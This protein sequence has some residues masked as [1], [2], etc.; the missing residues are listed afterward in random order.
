[1][2][3]QVLLL[4][5]FVLLLPFSVMAVPQCDDIFTDPP[6]GNHF[7]NGLYPPSDI[8]PSLGNLTCQKHGQNRTCTPA[9]YNYSPGDYNFAAGTFSQGN[10]INTNG[11]STRL[12]FDS[13][14]LNQARL[15]EFGNTE[16]LIIYVR[17]SLSI[18]GQNFINGIVY[19]AGSVSLSGNASIDGALASGGSLN[20]SGNGD[21]DFDPDAI[22]DADFGGMCDNDPQEPLLPPVPLQCPAEQ[23]GIGGVTY[24]SYDA[25][26]WQSGQLVSPEDH[27]EFNDLIDT[28]K[29]T[30]EQLGESI[31]SNISGYGPDINP[32]S[33]QGDYY[34]G[35]F[36]GY[37][38]VPES[39]TYTFGI[40]GDDAI[41]LLIDDQ[42]VVGFYGLHSRCGFACETGTIGLEAGTHKVE[43]RF[44]EADGYEA[45]DLYWQLPSSS[46]LVRVPNTVYLTCPFPEFEFGRVTLNDSGSATINFDNQY[47]TSPI[48]L[49]MPT[50][51][52]ID[53]SDARFDGPS[54]VQIGSFAANNGSVTIVQQNPPRNRTSAKAMVDIDYFVMEPGYRFLS[55]GSALQAD[56]VDTIKY[57][58]KRLPSAGRGYDDVEF[59]H[60][61]GASPAIVAQ[62]LSK[63][64]SRFITPIVN[65]IDSDGD[66]FEIAIEASEIAGNITQEETLGYVAGLGR[67]TMTVNGESVLYEFATAL[68]HGNGNRVRRLDQQCDF[69]NS[70]QNSYPAQPLT[71]ASKNSRRGGDGGWIRRCLKDSFSGTFSFGLDEDEYTDNDRSHLAETI[72]YF[73]FE[74]APEP[75]AVNHYRIEFSSGA[76]S[77]AAKPI[78]IRSCAND[79]CTT[80]T[81]VTSSVELLKDGALYSSVTMTGVTVPSVEL[82]H[83]DGG[84][85]LLGLGNTVPSGPYRC[86]I[87]GAEVADLNQCQ[88]TFDDTGFY[89]DVPNTLAGKTTNQFDLFAV[90]KNTQTQQCVP[91]FSQQTKAID[92]TFDYVD[93]NP[94]N[95]P[96]ALLLESLNPTQSNDSKTIAGA[97][98]QTLNVEFDASG[99]ARLQAT[100]PEAGQVSLLASHIHTI[101][102]PTGT[103]Q[104][105]LEHQ[106]NFV[107]APAGFHFYNTSGTNNCAS[108]DPYDADCPVLTQAGEDFSMLMKAVIWTADNDTDFS[109]NTALQNFRHPAV[110]INPVVYQPSSGSSGAFGVTSV[111]F[112]LGSGESAEQ[113]TQTWNEVGVVTAQLSKDL[114]YFD[115][116]IAKANYSSDS[117]GRFTPAYL[118]IVG[119]SP[120]VAHSCNS[121]TYMDQPMGFLAGAEPKI[122]VIGHAK[123]GAITSNYQIGDWWRYMHK[124]S[125]EQNQWAGRRY[126]DTTGIAD[127]V[128]G[129]DP[130]LSGNVS[131]LTLSAN[132]AYLSG[133]TA[134]YFR[135][136]SAVAP[137]DAEF[138]LILAVGD[139]SDE[140]NICY[141]DDYAGSCQSYTFTEIG[142]DKGIEQR[143]GRMVLDNGYGPQSESLRLPLRTEYVSAVDAVSGHPTWITNTQDSCSV[144]NTL[145]ST[146]ESEIPETGLFMDYPNGFPEIDAFIEPNL[147][148]QSGSVSNGVGNIYFEVPD[149]AGEVPLKQHVS[150]WLKW[151]WNWDGSS[152][153][154]YDPRA[155]AFWG[156][157]RGHDKVIFWREVR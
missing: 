26:S 69:N 115:M 21:V 43:V 79:D 37:I 9:Y 35:I 149:I 157:Y 92:F 66:E 17:G 75:P 5:V 101:N 44:H 36:E 77:C 10:Y 58:G 142:K 141:K 99:V 119:N 153:T 132:S 151:Y 41:E 108:G 135:G 39:G 107:A 97:A 49:L 60:E 133:G 6:T 145:T 136:V 102:T 117:F 89:F 61:F 116:T 105:L 98:T 134:K 88:L 23:T 42:V 86:F 122:E 29:K 121:F 110:A 45:Y 47:D 76:L 2:S 57:Q 33:S 32:H 112:N 113:I 25:S 138:E 68:N 104:L 53:G 148:I 128:D 22:E 90:T 127:V 100:Y 8:G 87:D 106:D 19:V 143:Y 126:N 50:I 131:Y 63:N 152:T 156:T 52:G 64:N 74:Y 7:P 65:D 71:I 55:R 73:A 111:D 4:L 56:K 85:V 130:S 95:N 28:V 16:D 72:G 67:G 48:V 83:G 144:V 84:T 82:W 129:E 31:E 59:T 94:V 93:P 24:R 124:D 13:L 27:D 125:A 11:A 15:N 20:I 78:T 62:M 147:L 40:D 80:L 54:D 18:A 140:D 118:E 103:E 3:K 114:A 70:Y 137:F 146:D 1:M 12:Y 81:S 91:L 120:E 14:T 139:V 96:E 46:S 154:L 123:S 30:T 38:N 34:L 150:P 155:S 51:N 109:D